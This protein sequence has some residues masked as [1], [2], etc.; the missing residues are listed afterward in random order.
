MES[1]GFLAQAL[2]YLAAAVIAVPL[3]KRLGLGSVLGFLL[4]GVAIGPW[5]LALIG[6]VEAMLHFS[7]FGVVLLLFLV[8]LELNSQPLWSLR[9]SIFGMGGPRKTAADRAAGAG[10]GARRGCL[11]AYSV[12][13]S[14]LCNLIIGRYRTTPAHWGHSN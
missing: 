9:R 7:E 6:E 11:V 4:A 12:A 5:G 2:I 3:S 10:A 13:L 1:H 8:G 14:D